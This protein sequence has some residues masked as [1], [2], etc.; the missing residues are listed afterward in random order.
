MGRLSFLRRSNSEAQET[1]QRERDVEP[2]C[3][4]AHHPYGHSN[5]PSRS[6]SDAEGVGAPNVAEDAE[7][8]ESD[9]EINSQ[10]VLTEGERHSMQY[11]SSEEST[12]EPGETS[13][14]EYFPTPKK[15][16]TVFCPVEVDLG[17]SVFFSAKLHSWLLLLNR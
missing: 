13:E 16:R 1:E 2:A 17:N 9:G 15:S 12:V 10:A 11:T 4:V 7:D 14:S 5:I 3:H 8:A 6:L